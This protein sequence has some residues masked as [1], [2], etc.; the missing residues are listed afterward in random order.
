MSV[1]YTKVWAAQLSQYSAWLRTGRPGFD[2]RQ[3]QRIFPLTS[4]SRPAVGPTQP[5]VQR[6]LG[7][8]SSGVKRCRGVM[9]TTHLLL[10]PR[11][12][13]S[14]SCILLSPKCAP[15]E[16][17]GTTLPSLFCIKV[18][19]KNSHLHFFSHIQNLLYMK[20]V[21]YRSTFEDNT[22]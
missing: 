16:R 3:R 4:A 8:L 12:R 17:N 11:L 1:F 22:T 5:P 14:R 2:P 9:L 10:V 20:L 6:V 13:K 15:I 19:K 7:A 21:L 18:V